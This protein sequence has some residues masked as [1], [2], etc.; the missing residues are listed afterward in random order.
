MW[1]HSLAMLFMSFFCLLILL[2][3]ELW[4]AMLD[5]LVLSTYWSLISL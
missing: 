1:V 3:L 4:L 2:F 5:R